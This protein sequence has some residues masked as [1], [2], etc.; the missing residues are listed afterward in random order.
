MDLVSPIVAILTPFDAKN[1]IDFTALTS[2]LEYLSS[3]G[4]TSIITNGTTAEFPSL[5][6]D[7][8]KSLLEHCSQHFDGTIINHVSS[9]C[10]QEIH[11]LTQHSSEL[12]DYILVL[13]P[14]YYAHPKSRG[15]QLFFEEM[16]E[17]CPLPVFLYNFPRHVQYEIEPALISHLKKKFTNLVGIKDSSGS[18]QTAKAF[19]EI[20]PT[21]HVF[22]GSDTQNFNILKMGFSGSV[23]GSGSSFPECLVKIRE[24]FFSGKHHHAQTIQELFNSE[25]NAWRKSLAA[26][27][28]SLTKYAVSVRLKEFPVFVRPP[29]V[30]LEQKLAC[31]VQ[32]K[33]LNFQEQL[34][35]VSEQI[36]HEPN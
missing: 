33:V 3:R 18:I 36:T 28:I 27:E 8:R 5:N 6:L 30:G 11:E 20:D 22:V 31:E 17:A 10:L 9:T 32:S 7:E 25:W 2:Y 29:M 34:S 21:L 24:H 15:V 13:P 23:T 14:F 12:A 35:K 4:V 26:D 16:L 19:I 1:R